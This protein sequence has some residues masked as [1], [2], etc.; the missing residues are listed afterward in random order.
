MARKSNFT[1]IGVYSD[2]GQV[3]AEAV[4]ATDAFAPMGIIAMRMQ[5]KYGDPN[6]EIVG[7]IQGLHTIQ[8]PCNQSGKT[9]AACHCIELERK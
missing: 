8:P 4:N 2:N 3:Y 1:V 5:H 7:A 9:A 6:L